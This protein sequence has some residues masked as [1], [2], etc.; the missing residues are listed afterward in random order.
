[1]TIGFR[2]RNAL[3]FSRFEESIIIAQSEIHIK[4]AEDLA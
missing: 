2:V 3:D 4:E 1:M